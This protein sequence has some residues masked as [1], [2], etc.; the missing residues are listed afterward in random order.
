M[1]RRTAVLMQLFPIFYKQ[2]VLLVILMLITVCL[3]HSIETS[4]TVVCKIDSLVLF[5][6]VIM[7]YGIFLFT[8]M[9]ITGFGGAFA[10]KRLEITCLHLGHELEGARS[11]NAHASKVHSEYIFSSVVLDVPVING[12]GLFGGIATIANAYLCKYGKKPVNSIPFKWLKLILIAVQILSVVC[13]LGYSY[14]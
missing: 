13:I 5:E 11:M 2:I 8:V 10:Y 4:G 6:K 9:I 3:L 12:D 7:P 1:A 14:I